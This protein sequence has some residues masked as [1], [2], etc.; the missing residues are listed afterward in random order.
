MTDETLPEAADREPVCSWCGATLPQDERGRGTVCDRCAARMKESGLS[1]E[2]IYG[3]RT[4][5]Q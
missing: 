5:N 3:A 4:D 2:E 1:D